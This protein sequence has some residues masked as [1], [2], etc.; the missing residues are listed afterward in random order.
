LDESIKKVLRTV[1]SEFPFLKEAKE[2]FFLHARRRLAIPHERDFNVLASIP[3][4]AQECFVDIGANHGQSIESIL[5]LQPDARIVSFE[6]NR[7]LAQ[8]LT[9]RYRCHDNVRVIAKGLSD[10]SGRSTLFVPCTK[11]SFTMHWHLSTRNPL[12][13]GLTEERSFALIQQS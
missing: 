4:P 1:Q 9:L 3:A 6:A 10:W 5:L 12:L 13:L 2:N 7:P 11:D 8:K